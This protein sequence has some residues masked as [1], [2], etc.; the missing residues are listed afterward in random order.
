MGE[1]HADSLNPR[2]LPEVPEHARDAQDGGMA[3]RSVSCC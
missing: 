1:V 3:A 2:S